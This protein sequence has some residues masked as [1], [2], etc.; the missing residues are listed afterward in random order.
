MGRTSLTKRIAGLGMGMPPRLSA[1]HFRLF[2]ESRT[3]ESHTVE[4]VVY[5]D[6][7]IELLPNPDPE[8]FKIERIADVGSY[9]CALVYYPDCTNFEGR[10]LIVF[11]Q[12]SQA[13]ILGLNN[14]DP[15]FEED[16]NVIARFRPDDQGWEDALG[17]MRLRSER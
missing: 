15:H 1:S 5:R 17:L 8:N 4:R 9:V 10:K 16:G 3:P 7:E 14:L 11:E 2:E 6:R 12:T 13:E